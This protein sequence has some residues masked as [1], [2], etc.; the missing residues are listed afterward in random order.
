[1]QKILKEKQSEIEL[2]EDVKVEILCCLKGKYS[3]L[4][5]GGLQNYTTVAHKREMRMRLCNLLNNHPDVLQSLI[6]DC[7]RQIQQEM[8]ACLGK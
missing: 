4:W 5:K 2:Y 8:G 6:R 3:G 7:E 1:M